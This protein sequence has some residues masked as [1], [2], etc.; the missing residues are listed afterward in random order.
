MLH[1]RLTWVK[2]QGVG[3]GAIPAIRH[4]RPVLDAR[5]GIS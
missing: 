2:V 1:L 3:P 4:R 5:V